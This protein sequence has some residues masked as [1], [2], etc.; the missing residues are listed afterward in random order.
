MMCTRKG[1]FVE[2]RALMIA[3]TS[4][5][6]VW[7]K[8]SARQNHTFSETCDFPKPFVMKTLGFPWPLII[9]NAVPGPVLHLPK[10]S[11][12]VQGAQNPRLRALPRVVQSHL[13]MF[14]L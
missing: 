10:S 8:R 5:A 3:R 4:R 11:S 1:C 14:C 2:I 6:R 9:H 7:K 12:G 13:L